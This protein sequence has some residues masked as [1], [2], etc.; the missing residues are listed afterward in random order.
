MSLATLKP[1]FEYPLQLTGQFQMTAQSHVSNEGLTILHFI[2]DT[3]DSTGSPAKLMVEFMGAYLAPSLILYEEIP[4]NFS[5]RAKI[6]LHGRKIRELANKIRYGLIYLIALLKLLTKPQ[7]ITEF[8]CSLPT[9]WM[10]EAILWW[11]QLSAV[12]WNKQ[13][14]FGVFCSPL[15]VH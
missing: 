14:N 9:R 3:L 15:T 11:P 5:D 10:R 4:V 8:W 13:V 6:A 2:L 1:F 12:V 7:A